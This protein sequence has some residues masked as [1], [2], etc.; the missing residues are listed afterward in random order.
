MFSNIQ[1]EDRG[2]II[3][4]AILIGLGVIFLLG[5]LGLSLPILNNWWAIFIAIPGIAMLNNVYQA[6]KR[7]GQLASNDFVQGII[8][9]LIVAVAA[10]FLFDFDLGFL[11]N[12][13]PLLLILVG[14]AMLFGARRSG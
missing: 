6:Y 8:G 11:W 13:W 1:S 2:R 3:G 14:L 5:Q 10:S 12:W 7:N 9:V 4:A